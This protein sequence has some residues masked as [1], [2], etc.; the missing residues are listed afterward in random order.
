MSYSIF[1]FILFWVRERARERE[2]DLIGWVVDRKVPIKNREGGRKSERK[3][4]W[5]D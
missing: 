3:S 4:R 5:M 2:K 1:I